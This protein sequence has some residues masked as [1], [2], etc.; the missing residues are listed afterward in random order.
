MAACLIDISLKLMPLVIAA[1]PGLSGNP[2]SIK[3]KQTN[4]AT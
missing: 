3:Q 4:F 1:L 2:K